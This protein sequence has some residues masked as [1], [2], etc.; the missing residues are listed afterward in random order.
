MYDDDSILYVSCLNVLFVCVCVC[1]CVLAC[2]CVISVDNGST[3]LS[4]ILSNFCNL[5]QLKQ[6]SNNLIVFF[7]GLFSF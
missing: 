1:V 4:M 2:V 5:N 6:K 7:F 3:V